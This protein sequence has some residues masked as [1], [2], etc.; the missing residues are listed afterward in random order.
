MKTIIRILSSTRTAIVLIAIIT[1][2]AILA[3]L[4]P[5]QAEPAFYMA[6]YGRLG[7]VIVAVHFHNFW[8]SVV[9]LAPVGL[10]FLNLLTCTTQRIVRRFRRK[11]PLRLGPDLIHVGL[12]VL[13][14]AGVWTLFGRQQSMMYVAADDLFSL[15]DG[16]NVHL[17]QF[18]VEYYEDLRPKDWVSHLGI[19]SE[20]GVEESHAIE[21]NKPLRV[22]KYRLYQASY[23]IEAAATIGDGK[24]RAVLR[25]GDA[26]RIGESFLVF[27]LFVPSEGDGEAVFDLVTEQQTQRRALRVGDAWAGVQ[28]EELD[29]FVQSGIQIV[30]QPGRAIILIALGLLCAGL[31]LTFYQKLSDEPKDSGTESSASNRRVT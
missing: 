12:L 13:V 23:N 27:E 2:L 5:Q 9:F 30:R 28:L 17:Q 14:V 10:F 8:R 25:P 24:N 15:P 20:E 31:G 4:V 7:N 6:R 1:V 16:T 26:I 11:D 3:T 22:G 19:L 21:V 29:S 18:D